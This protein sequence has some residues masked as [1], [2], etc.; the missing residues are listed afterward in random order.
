[1]DKQSEQNKQ[2]WN[3]RAHEFWLKELGDPKSLARDMLKDPRC[4]LRRYIDELGNLK[5]K[6]IINPLG[7][8][9][10]KAIPLAI[11]GANV[12]VV[13]ISKENCSYALELATEANVKVEYIV[14]DFIGFDSTRYQGKYDMVFLEGG[15]LHYFSDLNLLAKK[16]YSLLCEG[17]RIILNDFHPF[18]K[19]LGSQ[20]VFSIK[21]EDYQLTGDYFNNEL[22]LGEVAYESYFNDEERLDF[23]KCL[24]RY[25]TMGEI[26]TSFALAGF[27]IEKLDEGP[28][29]DEHKNL[30]GEFTL[31]AFKR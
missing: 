15:I 13:D 16:S 6:K 25:W 31:I 3:Y 22:T 4:F 29:F 17:G 24:L 18:R 21:E 5:G 27:V 12:T 19:V 14:S 9:G 2:A 23:P 28:R 8:C 30:P 10:K 7:S 1:M 11:L 20:N 26:I